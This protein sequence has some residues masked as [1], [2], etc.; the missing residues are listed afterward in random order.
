MQIF[1]AQ[2]SKPVLDTPMWFVP[3]LFAVEIMY[4][5]ISKTK[6]IITTCT[7]LTC[8]GWLLESGYLNFDNTLL[9]WSLDSALFAL[10]FYAV[11]NL[12]SDYVKKAISDIK[13]VKH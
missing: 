3:C 12:T 4:Y 9:P 8:V 5:L 10:G 7:I 6:K 1:L 11:G 2:G 13:K